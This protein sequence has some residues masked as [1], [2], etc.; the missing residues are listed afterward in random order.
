MTLKRK[1]R[2]WELWKIYR[3]GLRSDVDFDNG[4][5]LM[6]LCHCAYRNRYKCNN[7]YRWSQIVCRQSWLWFMRLS[8]WANTMNTRNKYFWINYNVRSARRLNFPLE[9]CECRI[10]NIACFG[11]FHDHYYFLSVIWFGI[12]LPTTWNRK[13]IFRLKKSKKSTRSSG[14]MMLIM[15]NDKMI[16]FLHVIELIP[17]E[18]GLVGRFSHLG[19]RM[20]NENFLQ[21]Q[22]L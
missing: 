5:V 4:K 20:Q 15:I 3:F 7:N 14:V 16:T 13:K 10:W 1:T 6:V 2:E 21:F 12:H 9:A 22:K 8:T 18:Y 17:V 19:N 11:Q